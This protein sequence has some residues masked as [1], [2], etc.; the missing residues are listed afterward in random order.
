MSLKTRQ[1][2]MGAVGCPKGGCIFSIF[3]VFSWRFLGSLKVHQFN[4][5]AVGGFW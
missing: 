1:F 3:K 2:K 5:D 4:G